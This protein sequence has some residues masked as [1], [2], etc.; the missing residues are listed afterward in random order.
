ME[1][2]VMAFLTTWLCMQNDVFVFSILQFKSIDGQ[3]K[4][5][6]I[7]KYKVNFS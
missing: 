1:G 3:R 5:I 4:D 7:T 2:Q 6:R